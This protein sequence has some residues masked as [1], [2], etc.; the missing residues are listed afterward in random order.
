MDHERYEGGSP[1]AELATFAALARDIMLVQ[2]KNRRRSGA[3]AVDRAFH[4][5]SALGVENARLV[6]RDDLPHELRQGCF[7][8]GAE[9]PVA[10]RLSNAGGIAQSDTVKDMRGAAIRIDGGQGRVHDLLMTDYEVSPAANAYQFV[11]MAQAMAGRS[12]EVS[13]LIGLVTRLP[14]KVGVWATVRIIVNLYRSAQPTSSLAGLTYWSRGAIRWGAAGPVRYRLRP[15]SVARG[16]DTN[17]PDRLHTDLALRLN[18][19]DIEFELGVQ[20]YV[21]E[22]LTPVE[23]TSKRWVGPWEP[24]ARLIVPRQNLDTAE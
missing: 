15:V 8:P 21:S 18:R 10:V 20:R 13:R 14:F 2:A 12:S 19:G 1:E 17:D 24:V 3:S 9:F 11:A 7:Q 5:K 22:I 6:V 23:N 16:P 4:A